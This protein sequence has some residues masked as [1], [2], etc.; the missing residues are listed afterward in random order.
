MGTEPAFETLRLVRDGHVARL[1]LDRPKRKNA[2]SPQMADELRVALG[3]L[4]ADTSVRVVVLRG[5][6]GNFCSGGDLGA[7]SS[8]DGEKDERGPTATTVDVMLRV[9]GPSVLALHH[10]PKPIIAAV[11]GVA[12]GAGLNLALACDVVYAAEGARFC[13]IFVHRSLT[14]DC[15]GTWLL[16]RLVGLNKAKE[17]AMF[18]EWFDAQDAQ[19]IG[20]VSDVFSADEFDAHIE[21]RAAKLAKLPPLAL[22]QI[23]LGLN[24]AFSLTMAEALELEGTAQGML[25]GTDDFR[26]GMVAFFKKREP[27][28]RGR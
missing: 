24:R 6:E 11:E 18:G 4:E 2:F 8:N 14:V 25:A 20:V 9:Y 27:E 5:A 19:R 16:P 3:E 1:T 10:F 28:F 7:G 21:E 15:G 23:K 13:E 17:L 12:A 22:S 26:E